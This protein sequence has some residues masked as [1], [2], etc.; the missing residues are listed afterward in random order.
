MTQPAHPRILVTGAT[1]R[2]G[3]ELVTQLARQGAAVR[4]ATREPT[5]VEAWPGVDLVTLDLAAPSMLE[6]ALDGIDAV[7]L[8]WPFF[9]SGEAA[10][11]R[12]DSVAE[13]LADRVQRV[14]YL[15]SQAAV[16][17]PHAFW[18][19]V[20]RALEG[21]VGHWT[22]L[23]PTGFAVNAQM[24]TNQIRS[25]DVVRWPFGQAARSLI[26]ECDIAAVAAAALLQDGHHG[27]RYVITGPELVT[28]RQ[29]VA[30]I[31]AALGRDLRWEEFDRAQAERELDLPAEMLDAWESFIAHPEPVTDEVQRLTG[32]P[33]RSFASWAR[34]HVADFSPDP[35]VTA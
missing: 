19:V 10:R 20:E 28:Q 33:A 22:M 26:H 7:Y 30:A 5:K 34:D 35:P 2:V 17:Q 1:G 23:R 4:I 25:G 31:G 32:E 9:Q 12:A 27:R 15:S 14:V 29:Q 18:A 13:I 6:P 3:R 16:E 11:E 8:M 21:T 24:W